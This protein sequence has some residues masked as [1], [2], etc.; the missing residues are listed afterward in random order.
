[1]TL[2]GYAFTGTAYQIGNPHTELMFSGQLATVTIKIGSS[3]SGQ[4]VRV[5]RSTDQG[6]TYTELSSCVV[7]PSGDCV[8]S[9]NQLSLFAFALPADTVPNAFSF[10]PITGAELSTLYTSNT[11][12]LSGITG[13]TAISITGGEYSINGAP[14]T[15]VAGS[16]NA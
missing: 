1:M 7:T 16:V 15:T 6:V 3:F 2:S 13:Q 9:T 5:F 14:F 8:F 11:I 10:T 12:T 4:T